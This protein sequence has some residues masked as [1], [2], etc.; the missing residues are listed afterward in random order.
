VPCVCRPWSRLSA[1]L[2]LLA[3]LLLLLFPSRLPAQQESSAPPLA[4]ESLEILPPSPGP[5]TLCQLRVKVRN[6]GPERVYRFGFDVRMNGKALPVYGNHLFVQVVAPGTTGEI[7]LF[8]FWTTETDRPMPA[9]GKLEIE[10][11]LNEAAWVRVEREGDTE[12]WTPTGDVDGL[13][14]ERSTTLSLR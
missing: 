9:D 4:L 5:E 10:V 1:L 13:P 3:S 2:T 14:I 11:T 8:N 7:R 12:I 6:N